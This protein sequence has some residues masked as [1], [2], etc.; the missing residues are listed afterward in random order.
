MKIRDLFES[1]DTACIPPGMQETMPPALSVEMD[2]YYEYYRFAVAIAGM[3]ENDEIPIHGPISD[4][5]W[6]APYTDVEHEHA[7]AVLK[8]MGKSPKHLARKPSTEPKWV[9]KSSPVR[10]FKDLNP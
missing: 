5:P 6:I 8:K 3:P 9:N 4:N 1:T 10:P 7:L 2:Q